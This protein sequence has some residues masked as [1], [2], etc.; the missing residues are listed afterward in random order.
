MET[1]RGANLARILRV[2]ASLTVWKCAKL[3]RPVC[4][5]RR[6]VIGAAGRGN[7]SADGWDRYRGRALTAQ[8]RPVHNAVD[9]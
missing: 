3:G 1:A 8:G 9:D 2:V 4:T 6:G 5:L 7:D